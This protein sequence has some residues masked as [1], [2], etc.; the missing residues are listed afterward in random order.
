LEQSRIEL[1]ESR[2]GRPEG[3]V[4]RVCQR[5]SCAQRKQG[6]QSL[7]V[8]HVVSPRIVSVSR[9]CSSDR[10]FATAAQPAAKKLAPVAKIVLV[11]S[12]ADQQ[13]SGHGTTDSR[14]KLD[15]PQAVSGLGA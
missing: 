14:I 15:D 4:G 12:E 9:W 1:V 10:I 2:T 7:V 6:K 3:Q 11:P 13:V 8:E 5:G